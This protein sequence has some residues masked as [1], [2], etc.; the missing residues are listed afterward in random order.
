MDA[1]LR[2]AGTTADWFP[3][4]AA[5]CHM[6][7][8]LNY[9]LGAEGIISTGRIQDP[10]GAKHLVISYQTAAGVIAAISKH[11]FSIMTYKDALTGKLKVD[12]N[13]TTGDLRNP[14]TGTEN[15]LIYSAN[16]HPRSAL[17]PTNCTAKSSPMDRANWIASMLTQMDKFPN[18]KTRIQYAHAH[19]DVDMDTSRQTGHGNA[20]IHTDGAAENQY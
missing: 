13:M 10:E 12:E 1:A 4:P 5:N 8:E 9:H 19:M 2:T 17:N 3:D 6:N 18:T 16:M 14:S 15:L 11:K 20:G 7:L